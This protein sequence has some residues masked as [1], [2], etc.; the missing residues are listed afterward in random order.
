MAG[1]RGG[2]MTKQTTWDNCYNDGWKGIIVDEAMSHPAKFARGLITRI[3]AHALAQGYIAPGGVVVDP[4]GGQAGGALPAM[5]AGLNWVGCEL[6]PR[7]VELGNQ[8]ITLWNQR[9]AAHFPRWG[10][11]QLLQ[12]DSRRLGDVIAAAGIVVSSP[13]FSENPQ[14]W[15]KLHGNKAGLVR[16]NPRTQG[17]KLYFT[18]YIKHN[19]DGNLAAL[20]P[21]APPAIITSPPF[22]GNTGGRGEASRNGIDAALFDRHSGGMKKGT[23]SDPANLDHLPMGQPIAV[24]SPPY[25]DGCSHTGGDDTNPQFIKGSKVSAY[26]VNGYGES[27]G[28]L[29]AMVVGSPPFENNGNT[30]DIEFM[31]KHANDTG[32][33]P[34][35][36]GA[37]SLIN[38]YGSTPNQLGNSTG[39]T[40]WS[41]AALIVAQCAAIL[42]PGAAAIWVLKPYVKSG[43]IVDFPGQWQALCEACGFETVEV[44]QASL[45]KRNGT[46]AAMDG[47]AV[48]KDVARK[49]FFRRLH[50]R[51]R[52]DLAI[53]YETVLVTVKR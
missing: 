20:P 43:A 48:S 9:Y 45:V 18:D 36:G 22:A 23:G 7:F 40:F 51:K 3:I 32:R 42:P 8:N 21:G 13:P 19:S 28:Q 6:E 25:A 16:E 2:E 50:E 35:T 39:E 24:S 26:G 46:Q 44:I 1:D 38:D 41:A 12:G 52:P 30:K 47:S 31:R 33:N 29:G 17:E 14:G 4:F 27:D 10:S 15:D 5:Q 11:A 34:E 37:R 49:S 53:D